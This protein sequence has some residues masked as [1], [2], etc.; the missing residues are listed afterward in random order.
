MGAS[1]GLMVS[2]SGF[3]ESHGP[4]PLGDAHGIVPAHRHGP[5]QCG[6]SSRPMAAFIEFYEIHGP[7]SLGDA[8]YCTVAPP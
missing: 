3:Y 4:P 5:E 1:I 8:R 7:P 6:A 2:C